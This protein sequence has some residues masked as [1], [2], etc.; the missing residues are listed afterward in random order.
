MLS[1][2]ELRRLPFQRRPVADPGTRLVFQMPSGELLAPDP[3]FT[4]GDVWWRGPRAVY[5]VDIR[6]HNSSF[7]CTLP[8]EGDALHFD[9]SIAFAWTV[10]K[11][12]TVVREMV[13]DPPGGCRGHLIQR[14][15]GISR[16]YSALNSAAA[17]RAI[18]LE[19]GQDSIDL[20]EIGLRITN[21]TVELRLDPAQAPI[22]K[23]LEIA[24]LRQRLAEQE[25][26]GKAAINRI[27]QTSDL[28]LHEIR[29]RFYAELLSGGGA[30]MA[31]NLLAQDP[32]KAAE[33]ADFMVG[34][35]QRDQEVAMRAMKVVLE[36]DQL[37][38]GEIDGAV[39]AA[40]ESFTALVSQAG[41]KLAPGALASGNPM[42][43]P[44]PEKPDDSDRR[45]VD[46]D[47]DER[48]DDR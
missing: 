41:N 42:L 31:G 6:P 28:Q 9:A 13:E 11:P 33:A 39:S 25:E 34:L 1:K 36:S 4:T 15:R 2:Q 26:R 10:H 24:A 47:S 7:Q 5:V 38:L 3:P 16:R 29:A 17:E 43:A 23:D 20:E 19:L 22:A 37:R 18:S 44:A 12:V 8:S 14:M 30:S 40:V 27:A 48:T 46:D 21:F 45:G 32:T 35:W